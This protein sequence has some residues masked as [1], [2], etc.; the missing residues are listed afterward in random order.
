MRFRQF[1]L[2]VIMLCITI[3]APPASAAQLLT[4]AAGYRGPVLDLAS[5]DSREN[6]PFTAAISLP[7][8]ITAVPQGRNGLTGSEGYGFGDN[9]L[10]IRLP[11][12]GSNSESDAISFRFATPVSQFGALMNYAVLGGQPFGAAPVISAFDAADQLI[13]RFDLSVLAPIDT[14]N[15]LNAFAFRG[16]SA[17]GIAR[18]DVAGSFIALAGGTGMGGA[19]PEPASWALLIGGFGLVGSALRRARADA[20]AGDGQRFSLAAPSTPAGR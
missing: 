20:G 9:G 3:I 10:S 5:L 13:A 18:F 19:V 6:R 11:I 17:A 7:G 4:S 14:P 1:H 16:I 2:P 15:A 8:G 12:I